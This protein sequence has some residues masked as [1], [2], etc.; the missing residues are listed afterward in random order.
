M[1]P[2]AFICAPLEEDGGAYSGAV[3]NGK[4]LNIEDNALNAHTGHLRRSPGKW[5]APS[6]ARPSPSRAGNEPTVAARC[7]APDVRP[8]N[9]GVAREQAEGAPDL[10]GWLAAQKS[11]S[12]PVHLVPGPLNGT[13]E[14]T[15][16]LPAAC[17]TGAHTRSPVV[18][19]ALPVPV[20]ATARLKAAPSLSGPSPAIEAS[21]R[22]KTVQL[23]RTRASIYWQ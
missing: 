12:A 21:R 18:A 2:K 4:S 3:M 7:S 22:T 23:H 13:G 5:A 16:V 9:I 19:L 11:G 10:G 1:A 6:S 8:P 14:A 17:R 20:R 15:P